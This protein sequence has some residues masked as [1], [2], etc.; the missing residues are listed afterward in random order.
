MKKVKLHEPVDVWVG[1]G[2]LFDIFEQLMDPVAARIGLDLTVLSD[3]Q[4]TQLA[5]IQSVSPELLAI[6]TYNLSLSVEDVDEIMNRLGNAAPVG[7]SFAVKRRFLEVLEAGNETGRFAH[8]KFPYLPAP[9]PREPPS[10]FLHEKYLTM[11]EV[12][13][14]RQSFVESLSKRHSLEPDAWWGRLLLSAMTFGALMDTRL[15]LE[16]PEVFKAADPEL[17]WVLLGQAADAQEVTG[18]EADGKPLQARPQMPRRWFLDSITRMLVVREGRANLPAMPRLDVAAHRQVHK[19]I[20]AYARA[21][22]FEHKLPSGVRSIRTALHT[23][24]HLIM[25]P[26]L[27]AYGSGGRSSASIPEWAWQRLVSPPQEFATSLTPRKKIRVPSMLRQ[28]DEDPEQTAEQQVEWPIQLRQLSRVLLN[29]SPK[30]RR[31][32]QDWLAEADERRLPSVRVIGEWVADWLLT[33]GRSRKPLKPRTV[34]QMVNNIAGRLV[35]QLGRM[36]LSSLG[37][38]VAYLELYQTVL[39]DVPSLNVRRRVARSLRSFHEYLAHTYEDVPSL[40]DSGLF[41]VAGTKWGLVDANLMSL[42]TFMRA[43]TWLD[44]EASKLY[45]RDVALQLDFIAVLGFFVGLRR[46][47]AVGLD[48]KAIDTLWGYRGRFDIFETWLEIAENSLR[49]LKTRS[50]HRNLP[51]ARFIDG[52]LMKGLLEWYG[53]RVAEADDLSAPLFPDF[54]R[55]GRAHDKD[56]RLALIVQA[57]QLAADDET[58]RYHHSRHSFASWNG[59]FFW[60][61]E[62]YGQDILPDWFVPAELDRDRFMAAK[63]LRQKLLGKAPTSRR[64]MTLVSALMGHSSL[65]ITMESYFHL[66]DFILGRQTLSLVAEAGDEILSAL[67]GYSMEYVREFMTVE[68]DGDDELA[69]RGRQAERLADKMIQGRH[70][71]VESELVPKMESRDAIVFLP[72][73][74]PFERLLHVARAFWALNGSHEQLEATARQFGL[75]SQ[76]LNDWQGRLAQLPVELFFFGGGHDKGA[77][78]IGDGHGVTSGDLPEGPGQMMMAERT[79]NV[80][81]TLFEKGESGGTAKLGVQ[82]RIGELLE[83]FP[84]LWVPGTYLAIETSSVPEAKRWLWFV[85]QLDI[86]DAAVISHTCSVGKNIPSAMRQLAY[87]KDALGRNGILEQRA[88][89]DEGTRGRVRVDLDLRQLDKEWLTFEKKT[90]LYGV[91]FMLGMLT[92]CGMRSAAWM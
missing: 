82:K 61:A 24:F 49:G 40:K 39:E 84:A 70:K 23:S 67:S 48:L 20:R 87:W 53:R 50:A 59:F 33:R 18:E 3:Q 44:H 73:A 75:R 35:G 17:R 68:A 91:R 85:E 8:I 79:L 15:L 6:E 32:V 31:R 88:T 14:L 65:D 46:S 63:R 25:P 83:M 64:S 43:L 9:P 60:L 62:Q 54:V 37:D 28:D 47:E 76:N 2:H 4:K 58:L 80:L 36:D 86:S 10:P 77:T 52:E 45:G 89:V 78:G 30:L 7:R 66:A 42:D 12:E 51:L 90:I 74:P 81:Q 55:R 16:L 1:W 22:G 71:S 21:M 57:L 41:V 11:M 72:P 5:A 34:Y 27:V 92:V 19:L 56:P 69:M 13:P 26:W 29:T 38:E